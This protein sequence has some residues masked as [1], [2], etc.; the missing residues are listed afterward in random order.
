MGLWM[1]VL[2]PL[3]V[4]LH[5]AYV[6]WQGRCTSGLEYSFA[7]LL[8][9]CGARGWVEVALG[10]LG[11]VLTVGGPAAALLLA[12]TSLFVTDARSAPLARVKSMWLGATA[13][14]VPISM[15]LVFDQ[16]KSPEPW[17]DNAWVFFTAVTGTFVVAASV[18]VYSFTTQLLSRSAGH[19]GPDGRRDQDLRMPRH[20]ARG[21]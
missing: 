7:P 14:I 1:G 18:V 8:I 3:G 6:L 19:T 21:S 9:S 20:D 11:T 17:G 4:S 16:T 5:A 13:L 2:I 15:V 10:A 12:A